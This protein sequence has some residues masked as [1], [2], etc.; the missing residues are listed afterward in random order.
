MADI[1]IV[2]KHRSNA[3]IWIVIAIVVIVAL[4]FLFVRQ[5]RATGVGQLMNVPGAATAFVLT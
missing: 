2:P 5:P 4:Y 3:W 1:D